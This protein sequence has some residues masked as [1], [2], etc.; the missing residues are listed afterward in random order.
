MGAREENDNIV[1]PAMNFAFLEVSLE[2]SALKDYWNTV[3]RQLPTL[4][5]EAANRLFQ[6]WLGPGR[7]GGSASSRHRRNA[8]IYERAR[9]GLE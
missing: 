7:A 1:I 2:L 4:A 9:D 5:E 8:H 6:E 3:E